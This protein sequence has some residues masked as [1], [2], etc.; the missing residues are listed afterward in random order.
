M[1]I[2]RR[3][4]VSGCT[5]GVDIHFA[6]DSSTKVSASSFELIKNFLKTTVNR[7]V[8]SPK[9]ARFSGSVFA[10]DARLI[11]NF[12]Q[13]KTKEEVFKKIDKMNLLFQEESN[14]DKAA[15]LAATDAFSLEGGT[16]QGTPKVFFLITAGNCSRCKE[17]LL[18]A[19][20]P[21]ENDGVQ[22]VTI[23]IGKSIDPSEL[24]A[25]SSKPLKKNLFVQDS[26]LQL[27]NPILIQKISE[28]VCRGEY[29]CNVYSKQSFK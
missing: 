5:R 26:V 2:I 15:R 14:M 18:D 7:F 6:I 11:F 22:I 10:D 19:V 8:V 17:R 24:Q 3:I 21:L 13:G 29:H 4:I 23:A 25:A 1:L 20:A 27:P 9:G 28:A 12:H 16:R